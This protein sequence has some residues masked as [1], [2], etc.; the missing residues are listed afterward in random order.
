MCFREMIIQTLDPIGK[1][2]YTEK[3]RLIGLPKDA[4][5]YK[6]WNDKDMVD[7]MSLW[8]EVYTKQQLVQWKVW[9]RTTIEKVAM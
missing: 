1:H 3:L 7:N 9:M 4:D 6:L 5:L 2:R 8:P